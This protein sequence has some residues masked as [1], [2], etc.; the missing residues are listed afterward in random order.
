[1]YFLLTINRL[2]PNGNVLPFLCSIRFS[3]NQKKCYGKNVK[4]LIS[5]V[6]TIICMDHL[7]SKWAKLSKKL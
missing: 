7:L 4:N 6:L 2:F 5:L 1:M 3:T